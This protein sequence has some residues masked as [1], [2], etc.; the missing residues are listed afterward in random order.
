M[1]TLELARPEFDGISGKHFD[2]KCHPVKASARSYESDAR[3][4]L[5]DA[6]AKL[7]EVS[8]TE[9]VSSG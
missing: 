7:V 8:P 3:Q 1:F 9:I 2:E 5:W 4:R 6:S